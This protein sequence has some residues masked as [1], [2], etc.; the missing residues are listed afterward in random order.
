M[1]PFSG[2]T[3][4]EPTLLAGKQQRKLD[5][6]LPAHVEGSIPFSRRSKPPNADV[7]NSVGNRCWNPR[8]G[9]LPTLLLPLSGLDGLHAL[10]GTL[11]G[12]QYFTSVAEPVEKA[13][14]TVHMN[15]ARSLRHDGWHGSK[16]SMAG[17]ARWR[18]QRS[19]AISW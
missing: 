15:A 5:N 12:E 11:N 16:G 18:T 4:Q 7:I 9:F 19:T 1:R 2:L 3:A 13:L 14:N 10:K 8:C 17:S 6:R